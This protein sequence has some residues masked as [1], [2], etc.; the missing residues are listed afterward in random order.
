MTALFEAIVNRTIPGIP[1]NLRIHLV[2]QI[3]EEPGEEQDVTTLQNVLKGHV[4]R[5]DAL[6]DKECK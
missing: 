3:E 2:R 1:S 5:E 4:E 6:E